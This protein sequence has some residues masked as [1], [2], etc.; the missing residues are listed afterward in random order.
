MLARAGFEN[1]EKDNAYNGMTLREWARMSLTERGIGVA[2]YNPM[3]MVG[4]A[5]THSTSD[6]GNIL[7]DVSNKG[8]IQGWEESEETFQKWTRKGR[9]S[10]FKTAYRVGMG[11]FGSLRQVRE[12]A[13]YKYITT[14]DRKETIAL[15]TYGEIFSITRQAIIND[16][17]NMLVDVPMK[18]G[19]AAKATIGDL[20]YKVLTDNPKLSD[21]KALFHAD[22]KNIATGGDLRFRTGCGPSDDA[23]AERRR[24]CPEYPSGLYAGTGGTGDGGEPDHQIG[25]C[26]RGGCKRRCH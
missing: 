22:H 4:L 1:V 6:F 13:E 26:E 12:G 21:G 19:R 7:L 16:D 2:S 23:P 10:D 15:A 25:Q 9:L 14:S 18:M 24:S 11:G 17:L 3:Q 8:L 5:L 20:V